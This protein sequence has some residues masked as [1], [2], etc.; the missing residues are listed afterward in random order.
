MSCANA[1]VREFFTASGLRLCL[2]MMLGLA[3]AH[4]AAASGPPT[5]GG[6]FRASDLVQPSALDPSIKLDIRYASTNNFIGKA[7]YPEA[8]AYLQRPA[9]QALLAVQRWLKP[10]GY[11]LLIHDAYR[12]WRITKLFWDT[13]PPEQHKFVADPAEGSR[14][15]RGCAVDISLYELASG[16]VV[17][18]PGDYDEMSERSFVTYTGGTVQQRAARDLLRTAMEREGEF[19]VLPEEWWHFDY[20]DFRQYAVED[21]PFD[22][23]TNIPRQQ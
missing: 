9:A 19:F 2:L 12:P 10:Q 7:L 6:P 1:S 16:H 14:H 3:G 5:A 11:G 15:N 4:L 13:T 17:Q 23:L 8:R 20:K 21:M 18:M 22:A